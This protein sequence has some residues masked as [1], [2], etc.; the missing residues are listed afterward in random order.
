MLPRPNPVG[1]D[2]GGRDATTPGDGL[3]GHERRHGPTEGRS[4][5]GSL[6]R[7]AETGVIASILLGVGPELRRREAMRRS[8]GGILAHGAPA[9]DQERRALPIGRHLHEF[10]DR[11]TPR[12]L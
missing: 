4:G 9:T 11:T 3:D 1:S 12:L 10:H 5:H 8:V 2:V 7:R 6:A